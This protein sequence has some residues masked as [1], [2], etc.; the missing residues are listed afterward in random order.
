MSESTSAPL[1]ISAST[2]GDD[3]DLTEDHLTDGLDLGFDGA[4]D[5]LRCWRRI[6]IVLDSGKPHGHVDLVI[7]AHWQPL[8]HQLRMR[9]LPTPSQRPSKARMAR[10]A[11]CWRA[12]IIALALAGG[13]TALEYPFM[14]L[15]KAAVDQTREWSSKTKRFTIQPP[16]L[17]AMNGV[18]G[19]GSFIP[20]E[21]S[22]A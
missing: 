1:P 9:P 10:W 16:P 2:S 5:I 22:S 7:A 18:A 3:G 17:P 20:Q 15:G 11:A 4:E 21:P 19:S 12:R 6:K 13:A 14:P 8:G